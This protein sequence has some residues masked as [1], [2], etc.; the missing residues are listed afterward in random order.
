MRQV[1]E[2][3][4]KDLSIDNIFK[5]KDIIKIDDFGF[6]YLGEFSKIKEI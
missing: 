2:T 1:K 4:E 3:I 5:H 6:G